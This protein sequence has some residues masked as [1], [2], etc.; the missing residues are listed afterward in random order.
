MEVINL[1]PLLGTVTLPIVAMIIIQ[2]VKKVKAISLFESGK[3]QHY[4]IRTVLFVLILLG[5]ISERLITGESITAEIVPQLGLDSVFQ[6]LGAL[7]GYE[8]AVR[9]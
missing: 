8:V 5:N 4:R 7:I 3:G 2:V 6:A 1:L 9:K